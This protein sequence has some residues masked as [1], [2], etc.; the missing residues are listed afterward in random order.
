MRDGGCGATGMRKLGYWSGGGVISGGVES[1]EI[2]VTIYGRGG[3]VD[4]RHYQH[5]SQ[6]AHNIRS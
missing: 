2:E 6:A 5:P 1:F 3:A 4:G